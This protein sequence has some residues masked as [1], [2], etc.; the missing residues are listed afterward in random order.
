MK[1]VCIQVMELVEL[2]GLANSIV[3]KPGLSGLSVEQR[4][5]LTI[6]VELVANPSIIF[7]VRP[8]FTTR[9]LLQHSRGSIWEK[10]WSNQ[11]A[12]AVAESF[13]MPACLACMSRNGEADLIALSEHIEVLSKR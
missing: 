12:Q 2:E 7:M 11:S 3:G 4:K 5:R 13:V 8:T 9:S 6:A 1:A 10:T